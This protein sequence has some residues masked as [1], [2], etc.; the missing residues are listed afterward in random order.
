MI[1][2][3]YAKQ[4]PYYG[5]LCEDFVKREMF[6]VSVKQYIEQLL[7]ENARL[8]TDLHDSLELNKKLMALIQR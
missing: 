1:W 8:K 2:W 3:D 4:T 6:D 7:D 5:E